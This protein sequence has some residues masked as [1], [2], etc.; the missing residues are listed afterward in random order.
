[1]HNTIAPITQAHHALHIEATCGGN[2]GLVLL[3]Q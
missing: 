2:M 1:M 3:E